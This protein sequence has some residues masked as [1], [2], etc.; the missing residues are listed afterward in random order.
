MC[1][2][3]YSVR[4][5]LVYVVVYVLMISTLYANEC[6]RDSLGK[7]RETVIGCGDWQSI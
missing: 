1:A 7:E 3:E 4:V 6:E 2:L 5:L